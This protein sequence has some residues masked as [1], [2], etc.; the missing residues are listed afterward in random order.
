MRDMTQAGKGVRLFFPRKPQH[1]QIDDK[2]HIETSLKVTP[3][4]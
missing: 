4:L 3:F 2:L 1:L